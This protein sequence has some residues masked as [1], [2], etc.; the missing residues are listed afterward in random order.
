MLQSP[1][2]QLV[3][4]V[5]DIATWLLLAG[6]AVLVLRRFSI[7]RLLNSLGFHWDDQYSVSRQ[8]R[9]RS[10]GGREVTVSEGR[11]RQLRSQATRRVSPL[12]P[13][14]PDSLSEK[15]L[16]R[17]AGTPRAAQKRQGRATE[18]WLSTKFPEW[19]T[20]Q[21][22]SVVDISPVARMAAKQQLEGHPL[23]PHYFLTIQLRLACLA[24]LA[25]R[26]S[27]SPPLYSSV[28]FLASA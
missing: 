27:C 16:R 15:N 2:T 18:A 17:A 9:D 8:V 4:P 12:D 25:L 20:P 10:L 6:C 1:G 7:W 23:L 5:R 24:F 3:L 26:L 22:G 13:V 19:W 11:Y 28:G 21:D 14:A